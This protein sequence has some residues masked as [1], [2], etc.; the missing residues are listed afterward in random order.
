MVSWSQSPFPRCVESTRC[1]PD[2]IRSSRAVAAAI[3]SEPPP[4]PRAAPPQ[5]APLRRPPRR[6]S[7]LGRGAGGAGGGGCAP[8]S[9]VCKTLPYPTLPFPSPCYPTTFLPLHSV[10]ILQVSCPIGIRKREAKKQSRVR[11]LHDRCTKCR[12]VQGIISTIQTIFNEF[13]PVLFPVFS[14]DR[15]KGE[16]LPKIGI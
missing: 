11:P 16:E 14:A 3:A 9:L 13:R 1:L 2:S 7:P 15:L 4:L 5:A 8:A 10:P 6:P 12:G